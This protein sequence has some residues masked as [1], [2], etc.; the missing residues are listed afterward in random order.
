MRRN[1]EQPITDKAVWHACTEAAR[2]AGL[3][4]R[5][6]PHTLRHS[7][8]THLLEGGTDLRTIQLL[9]GHGDLETT[10]R[11]LHLSQKHLQ[12]VVNPIDD[13]PL[14]GVDQTSR[15]YHGPYQR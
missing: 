2:R 5:V 13:L 9:L 8:A 1:P 12:Q 3:R 11:Y 10:A 7:W 4:K 14:A 6:S 15:S